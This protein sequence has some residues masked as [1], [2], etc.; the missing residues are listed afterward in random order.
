[1]A[2]KRKLLDKLSSGLALGGQASGLG[3]GIAST[4]AS[5]GDAKKRA[6]FQQQLQTLE[7]EKRRE[8]DSQIARASS[9][10]ERISILT[11]A[12]TQI[13]VAEVMKKLDK[14]PEN[15]KK[16]LYFII[17]GGVAVLLIAIVIKFIKK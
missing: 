15:N 14:K 13:R 12:V 4:L 8:L 5:I 1:M 11:Q 2:E 3:L 6:E 7:L 10:N 9:I 17:G 16:Q